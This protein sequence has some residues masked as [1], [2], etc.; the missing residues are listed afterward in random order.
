[1][2]LTVNYNQ[3]KQKNTMKVEEKKFW[4]GFT[5]TH[6]TITVKIQIDKITKQMMENLRAEYGNIIPK[7]SREVLC[8]AF[9]EASSQVKL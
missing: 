2:F 4:D 3:F 6:D 8:K 1:M 9:V 5:T 7:L